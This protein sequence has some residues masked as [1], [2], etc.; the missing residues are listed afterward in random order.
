M[1]GVLRYVTTAEGLDRRW[2]HLAERIDIDRVE[3]PVAHLG[4]IYVGSGT[5][6]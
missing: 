5:A 1:T 4:W 3:R 6:R 2:S